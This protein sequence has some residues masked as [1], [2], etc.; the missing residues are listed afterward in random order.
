MI[1]KDYGYARH[2]LVGTIVRDPDNTPIYVQDL[3]T[4]EDN[5]EIYSKCTSL[6]GRS[7]HKF[8]LD[9]LNLKP[10][11]LGNVNLMGRSSYVSRLPLRNDWRQGTRQQN[12]TVLNGNFKQNPGTNKDAILRSTALI[13]CVQNK[14]P[15]VEDA[16]ENLINGE[17]LGMSFSR[18]FSLTRGAGTLF[19]IFYKGKY[20]IGF[21]TDNMKTTLEKQYSHLNESLTEEIRK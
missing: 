10:L 18:K 1:Y 12:V 3:Y 17:Y 2:R 11:P 13:K 14:Y 16:M 4:D 20:F 15:S 19:N 5:G 21:M 6:S 8:K 7:H 9:E